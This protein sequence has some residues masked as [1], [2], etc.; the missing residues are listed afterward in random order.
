VARGQSSLRLELAVAGV[1]ISGAVGGSPMTGVDEQSPGELGCSL[2]ASER[3]R[4]G[5][6]ACACGGGKTRT[7]VAMAA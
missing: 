5:R 2:S 6:G 4:V 7:G 1:L 3:R